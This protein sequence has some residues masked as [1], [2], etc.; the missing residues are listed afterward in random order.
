MYYTQML[1]DYDYVYLKIL[2]LL[3]LCVKYID[4]DKTLSTKH[5][6]MLRKKTINK[7]ILKI[8]RVWAC[9]GSIYERLFCEK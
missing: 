2:L 9:C 1:K 6:W 5:L 3:L 7:I 4:S 8:E